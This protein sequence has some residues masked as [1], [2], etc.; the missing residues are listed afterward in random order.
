MVINS[1]HTPLLTRID[2]IHRIDPES[3]VTTLLDSLIR[4]LKRGSVVVVSLRD[5]LSEAV[6]MITFDCAAVQSTPSAP[7]TSQYLL[8]D[9][10]S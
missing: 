7:F 6:G 8:T 5:I 1:L 10:L 9:A 2:S 4:P 3:S